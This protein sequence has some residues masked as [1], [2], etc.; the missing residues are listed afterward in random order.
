MS[1]TAENMISL[2]ATIS[3]AIYGDPNH[4]RT[5]SFEDFKSDLAISLD[6]NQGGKNEQP[7]LE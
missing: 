2:C 4:W 3:E 1:D 6:Q 7:R 5:L